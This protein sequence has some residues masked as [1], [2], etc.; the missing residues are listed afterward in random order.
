VPRPSI[1]TS[2]AP[3]LAAASSVVQHEQMLMY[4]I[5][6]NHLDTVRQLL[7]Q[8]LSANMLVFRVFCFYF[9]VS[10]VTILSI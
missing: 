6:H 5:K 1:L 7:E 10:R 3:N 9:S 8:G 2:H 4:A